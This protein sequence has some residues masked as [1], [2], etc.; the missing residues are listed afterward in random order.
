MNIATVTKVLTSAP[1]KKVYKA[2]AIGGLKVAGA[3]AAQVVTYFAAHKAIKN[4]SKATNFE[5][6]QPC[7]VNVHF[8]RDDITVAEARA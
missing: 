5:P 6:S 7:T 3:T 1:A 8:L 4:I 2:V